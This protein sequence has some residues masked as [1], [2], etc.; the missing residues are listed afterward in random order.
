MPVIS[1]VG[2]KQRVLKHIL[3]LLPREPIAGAYVE[4]FLGGGSVLEAVLR[5]GVARPGAVRA[6]DANGALVAMHSALKRC[7]DVLAEEVRRLPHQ[8]LEAQEPAA[9]AGA[10]Q[11]ADLLVDQS[12]EAYYAVRAEYNRYRDP[13]RFVYLNKTCFNGVYRETR[14][15]AFNVPWGHNR[16]EVRVRARARARASKIEMHRLNAQVTLDRAA[17]ADIGALYQKYDVHFSV[18]DW[19]AAVS[20]VTSGDLCYLDPP[21]VKV[22]QASFTTY[23]ATDFDA[24]ANGRLLDWMGAARARGVRIIYSNHDT[25]AV[26]ARL[27]S[28]W[29]VHRFT[30]SGCVRGGASRAAEL[31]ACS[32]A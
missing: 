25:T 31:V 18:S 11:V 29:T 10:P 3:P 22:S 16:K 15:G 23:L 30:V 12:E 17:F 20:N 21:Y 2:G 13:A 7:P 28:G 24:A 14:H 32:Y 5:S 6:S 26:C 9:A 27:A 4:P 8:P 1:Y 19:A